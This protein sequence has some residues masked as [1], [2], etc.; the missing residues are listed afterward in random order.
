MP[1]RWK[2]PLLNQKAGAPGGSISLTVSQVTGHG[3]SV[4]GFQTL[5]SHHSVLAKGTPT[6]DSDTVTSAGK[7]RFPKRRLT[8]SKIAFT[9]A[10]QQSCYISVH[11]SSSACATYQKHCVPVTASRAPGHT[12]FSHKNHCQHDHYMLHRRSRPFAP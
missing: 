7:S 2:Q 12:Q 5:L 6:A 1:S 4:M 10:E 9:A 8:R 3:V 11:D